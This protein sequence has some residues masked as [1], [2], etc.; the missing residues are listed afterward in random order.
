MGRYGV[1]GHKT[2][3][4]VRE[5]NPVLPCGDG[6][7]E[8]AQAIILQAVKDYRKSLRM[9]KRNPDSIAWNKEK[10]DCERFF[11]SRWFRVLSGADPDLILEGLRKEAAV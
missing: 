6:Y 8:L 4:S 10:R 7:G 1:K 2:I 9:L 3:R 11:H 5:A